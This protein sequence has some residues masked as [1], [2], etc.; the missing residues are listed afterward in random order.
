MK[1]RINI[2]TLGVSDLEKSFRFYHQELGLPSK[3][4]LEGE[5]ELRI[6]F[7]QLQGAMLALFPREYMAKYVNTKNDGRGFPGFCLG[8]FLESPGE[9]DDTIAQCVNAGA[10]LASPPQ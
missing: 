6:A 2:I 5:G 7:F 10:T 3:D 1:P 8:H 4:G 9:V